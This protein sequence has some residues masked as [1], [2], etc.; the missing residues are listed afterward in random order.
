MDQKPEGRQQEEEQR[1]NIL[2]LHDPRDRLD[3]D[4]MEREETRGDSRARNG[5][6]PQRRPEQPGTGEMHQQIGHVVAEGVHAPQPP[7]Q[8]ECRAGQRPVVHGFRREPHAV[9]TVRGFDQRVVRQEDVIVPDELPRERGPVRD[10]CRD[11]DG[12]RNDETGGDRG[13]RVSC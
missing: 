13:H 3:V 7:L 1:Q 5:Q 9:E 2:A 8:P 4:R 11:S 12:K 6:P 10:K